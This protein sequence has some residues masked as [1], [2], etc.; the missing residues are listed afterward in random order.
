MAP[1]QRRHGDDRGH[2]RPRAI[3]EHLSPSL[4][5]RPCAAV[6]QPKAFSFNL[7]SCAF[8]SRY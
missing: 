7:E 5:N 2:K 6:I 3:E 1:P 4:L 8:R